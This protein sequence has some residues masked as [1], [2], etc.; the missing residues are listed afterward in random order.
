MTM[1]NAT[2]IYAPL[3]EP[4]ENREKGTVLFISPAE[5]KKLVTRI[6]GVSFFLRVEMFLFTP[7]DGTDTSHRPTRGFDIN[8]SLRV[9]AAQVHQ[10]LDQKVRFNKHKVEAGKPEG[11][12]EVHRLG[13]CLFFG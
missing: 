10:V 11:V 7:E 5:A 9:S 13:G 4:H 3:M 8:E 1:D 2:A 12:V 6:R